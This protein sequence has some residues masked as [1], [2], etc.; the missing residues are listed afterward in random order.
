[1]NDNSKLKKIRPL[2]IDDFYVYDKIWLDDTESFTPYEQSS[3]LSCLND[4]NLQ[5]S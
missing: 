1:M 3:L 2:A 4:P 5:A